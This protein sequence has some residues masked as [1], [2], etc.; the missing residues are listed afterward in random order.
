MTIKYRLTRAEI[1]Q[2]F[3]RSLGSSPRF[4]AIILIY[5]AALGVFSLVTRGAF[6]RSATTRD[7]IV[8]ISWTAGALVFMPLW[9][10][11][12]GK[13]DERTLTISG[14]GISTEIGSLR[15]QIPWSKVKLVNDTG[16]HVLI[17]GATGN[18]F[19]IPGRAF[20]GPDQRSEFLTQ[21]DCLR[22][23]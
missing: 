8:A 19:L 1:V 9:L 17:V 3:F 11:I 4:L 5:A 14:D 12:R 7:A 6:S 10:Y 23:P 20:Q 16:S 2:S 21:I 15:G 13:T 22:R 18:A